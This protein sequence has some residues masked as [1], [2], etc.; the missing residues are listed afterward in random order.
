VCH[1][2]SSIYLFR[3][4]NIWLTLSC[5]SLWVVIHCIGVCVT[6]LFLLLH[7]YPHA[8]AAEECPTF[9]PCQIFFSLHSIQCIILNVLCRRKMLVS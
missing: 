1:K 3:S 4:E 5:V 9:Y 8:G 6:V 7:F 2:V